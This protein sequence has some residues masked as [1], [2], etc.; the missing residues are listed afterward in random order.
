MN[1]LAWGAESE[2]KVYR[3]VVLTASLVG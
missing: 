3:G 2:K 1:T